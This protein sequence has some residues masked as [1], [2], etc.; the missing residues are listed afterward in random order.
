MTTR[1]NALKYAIG[2]TL[3]ATAI[4]VGG[5]AIAANAWG[6]LVAAVAVGAVGAALTMLYRPDSLGDGP[7]VIGVLLIVAA[8][9]MFIATF[10]T[11][12]GHANNRRADRRM[13]FCVAHGGSY[14]SG[15]CINSTGRR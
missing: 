9:V 3:T 8:V 6:V 4:A 12:E 5:V 13:E 7:V 10:A 11:R 14:V 1:L 15:N 2:V